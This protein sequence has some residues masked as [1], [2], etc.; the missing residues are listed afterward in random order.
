MRRAFVQCLILERRPRVVIIEFLR[1]SYTLFP[2]PQTS[3]PAPHTLIDT[4]D[5][6]HL[7]AARARARGA[8]VDQ[9]IDAARE[10]QMLAHYDAVLAIQGLEATRLREGLPGRTVL[11]VPHGVAVAGSPSRPIAATRPVRIG[12]LGGRD[13]SNRD[14]L[15]WFVREVWPGLHAE[16]KAQVELHVAGQVTKSW[17]T[18]AEGVRNLG[19][20]DSI[21]DFWRA[22]D[23]AINPVRYGSGLKIK[24]VE[25][26]AHGRALLTTSIG[27]EGLEA[28]GPDGLHIADS[29]SEWTR[30]LI[31]WLA[32]PDLAVEVARRG[33]EFAETHLCEGAAFAELDAHLDGILNGA[34]DGLVDEDP[35]AQP[36]RPRQKCPAQPGDPT[37]SACPDRG[38]S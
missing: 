19:P 28:A 9:P 11:V 35:D 10:W 23:I 2:L 15:D 12:F 31:E 34:L 7:R 24:N 14:A 17:S 1:L 33:R 18:T 29:A 22:I 4:H 6:L 25:A 37:P 16:W 8:D 32:H 20:V 3:H 26:L 27:A 36:G 5:I 38:A 30:V 13:A 21:D